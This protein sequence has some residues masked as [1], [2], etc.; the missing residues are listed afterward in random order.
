MG[1][2]RGT[3]QFVLF[4]GLVLE[5]GCRREPTESRQS[6][7]ATA[8]TPDGG[9]GSAAMCRRPKKPLSFTL[10]TPG[11][12]PE[13]GEERLDAPYAVEL[14]GVAPL[15]SG[16]A[17]AALEPGASGSR[18]I[19]AILDADASG[20]R[21]LDLGV[22]HGDS[23]PPRVASDGDQLVVAIADNDA[24]GRIIRVVAVRS[25]STEPQIDWGFDSAVGWEGA[26]SFD[27]SLSHGRG[28]LV[29]DKVNAGH[30]SVYFVGFAISNPDQ[31][32][33]EPLAISA[34]SRWAE[35]PRLVVREGGFWSAWLERADSDQRP[36][37]PDDD[38]GT[39]AV[40]EVE[41][42]QLRARPLSY[43][44]D[45]VGEAVPL[46]QSPAQVFAFDLATTSGGGAIV[47]WRQGKAGPGVEQDSVHVARI[48]LDGTVTARPIESEGVGA[49]VPALLGASEPSGTPWLALQALTGIV[50]VTPLVGEGL[51]ANLHD[52]PAIGA[53]EALV[54]N[55]DRL[56]I[57]T[58]RGRAVELSVV[59]CSAPTSG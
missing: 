38:A 24:A 12:A 23:P 15:G 42:A 37:T 11:P 10:G 31:P 47:A 51:G 9:A 44:G 19:L 45:S 14:G 53:S 16:F 4:A 30:R 48:K 57:A 26:T 39:P 29:W 17:V 22:V 36:G 55:G 43:R 2:S 1:F 46:H 52:E 18:A 56:L 41:Q 7:Q 40:L 13:E 5:P 35:S 49:G 8:R 6:S 21:V 50:Q 32:D 58:P 33:S 27:V 28:G 20:A 34:S 54:R 25:I 3:V 59:E